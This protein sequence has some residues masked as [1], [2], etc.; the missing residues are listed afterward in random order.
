MNR[1]IPTEILDNLW[2]WPETVQGF[3]PE[4]LQEGS[5]QIT[6]RPGFE[7]ILTHFQFQ[8][9]FSFSTVVKHSPLSFSLFLSG[10]VELSLKYGTNRKEKF[11]I[12]H[13]QT[14]IAFH[15]NS[16]CKSKY[17]EAQH[18]H[19][20]TIRLSPSFINTFIGKEYDLI[21]GDLRSIVECPNEDHY[22]RLGT[23][24]T[25]MRMTIHQMLN[26][27]Y[28]GFLK[29][30]YLESK[31]IEI[32]TH[33][34]AQLV[35]TEPRIKN[36]LKLRSYD[37]ERIRYARHILVK[38]VQNPPTI[39]ILSRMVGLNELKLKKGFHQIYGTSIY[40][41]FLDR[42]FEN[43][44]DLLEKGHMNVSEVAYAIGYS[45][46]DYFA[47]SFKKRFGT[48]PKAYQMACQDNK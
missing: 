24:T 18:L 29:Q 3:L 20:V 40:G 2:D 38:D 5:Q 9:D 10:K 30:M 36:N 14:F 33:M 12:G 23:I 21:P 6:L 37:I 32:I 17:L 16:L 11:R 15:P 22:Y 28:H 19:A 44:R 41:Y 35:F 13:N 42:R 7:L 25:S 48:T 45:R 46:L 27:P 34:L 47:S 31:A 4:Y 8:E 43:A 39:R 26:C 1:Q